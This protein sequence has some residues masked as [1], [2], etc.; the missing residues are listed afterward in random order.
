LEWAGLERGERVGA[1]GAALPKAS[2]CG[3]LGDKRGLP[4]QPKHGAG[5]QADVT[6]PNSAAR[7]TPSFRN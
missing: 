3:M 2:R 6:E 4:A 7:K 5:G 1:P